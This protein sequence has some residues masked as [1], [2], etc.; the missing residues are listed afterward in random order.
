MALLIS[1]AVLLV[2]ASLVIAF[3]LAPISTPTDATA[4]ETVSE[5]RI[6]PERQ[7]R[8]LRMESLFNDASGIVLLEAMVL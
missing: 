2:V 6:V 3:V 1:T 5:G 4:T 8:L 7:E